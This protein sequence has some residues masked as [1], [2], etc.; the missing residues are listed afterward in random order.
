[1]LKWWWTLA[2][3]WRWWHL[4]AQAKILHLMSSSDHTTLCRVR[5]DLWGL[6]C[7]WCCQDTVYGAGTQILWH[8]K[9]QTSD[10]G[11][12]GTEKLLSLNCQSNGNVVGCDAGS[13]VTVHQRPVT[14]WRD[15]SSLPTFFLSPVSLCNS[16]YLTIIWRDWYNIWHSSIPINVVHLWRSSTIMRVKFVSVHYSGICYRHLDKLPL[17]W[18]LITLISLFI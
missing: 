11:G 18:I 13:D 17:G 1:M 5:W 6:F 14:S 3:Y 12:E 15:D 16:Q 8:H 10:V 2:Q 9:G 7:F 4:D